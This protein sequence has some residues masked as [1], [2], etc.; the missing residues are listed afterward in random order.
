MVFDPRSVSRILTIIVASLLFAP[1]AHASPHNAFV[2][3]VRPGETLASI[4]Q[5]YYGDPRRESVLVAENGLT[6]HGGA[7]IVVGMR[8][9]I[10]WVSH[11]RV[12]EGET[13]AQLA[14]L[15][16]GDLRRAFLLIETNEGSSGGQPDVGAELLIPYPLRHVAAQNAHLRR[17]AQTYYGA[18]PD[19]VRMLRRMNNMRGLRPFRG[20]VILVPLADL[21]LSD[22]G[23]RIIEERTG[24]ELHGGEVRALQRDIEEQLPD[25]R[26]HLRRGRYEEVLA[27]GNRLLG[28]GAVTG[29]QHVTIQRSLGVAYV[30]LD[31]ED[32][33]KA[34]F[35]V[36]LEHQ[37]DLELDVTRTSP[38]VLR[39]FREAKAQR[40]EAAEAEAAQEHDSEAPD[41]STG[42]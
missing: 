29:N 34:A 14:E 28:G 1:Y 36:A 6:T 7:A 2:H 31:R 3:V 21:V 11:H 24:E 39:V 12:A 13:W 10:P 23:R 19:A 5:Q 22:N 8:L 41:A 37:P 35:L 15:Y 26:E 4:A 40:R 32:L 27:L 33:A 20:Q 17:I 18:D 38:R 25:L 9:V 30:A 42:E 16:Y